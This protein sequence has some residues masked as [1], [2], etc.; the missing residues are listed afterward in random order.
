MCFSS[1]DRDHYPAARP[2]GYPSTSTYNYGYYN[3]QR[4][5]NYGY[6]YKSGKKRRHNPGIYGGAAAGGAVA[7]SGCGGGG[8][9]GGGC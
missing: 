3:Q 7:A 8:G 4:P 1:S 5:M 9:G 2:S 6:G